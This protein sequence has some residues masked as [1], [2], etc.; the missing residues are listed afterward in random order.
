MQALKR[1]HSVSTA[2]IVWIGLLC[3]DS[4]GQGPAL[5]KVEVLPPDIN[6]NTTRDRQSFVVQATYA[7]GI[8]RD[9]TAESKVSLVNP[10]L[11]RLEKNVTYPVADGTTEMKVEFSGQ[12]VT[13][14]V[15]VKDAKADRPISFK[16]DVMP[17]F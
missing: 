7:D 14:P 11:V 3:A 12:T 16:L 9:V 6:L 2:A 8:T 13:V 1:T 15:V 10:A 5:T 4:F 17:V